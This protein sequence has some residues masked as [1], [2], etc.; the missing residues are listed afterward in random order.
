MRNS[1]LEVHPLAP[2]V[3]AELLG[4]DLAAPLDE[5]GF[6]EIRQAFHDHAVIF[7]RDQNLTPEQHLAFARRFG[8]INVNR[9]FTPVA[10]HPEI[11]EVRKE[12]DQLRPDPRARVPAAGAGG[13]GAR[14][15]HAIRQHV[16][17]L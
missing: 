16:R 1:R 3:G 17:R 2:A 9:F 5:A 6:A 15:R 4:V 12:P 10:G 11:A 14:R 13:A 7:F 8:A